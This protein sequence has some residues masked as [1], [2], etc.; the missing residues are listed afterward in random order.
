MS[1]FTIDWGLP[2]LFAVLSREFSTVLDIGSGAGEHKRFLEYHGK[3]VKSVDFDKEADYHGDFMD[4][5]IPEQFDMVWCSHVLEHQRNVG[6][7]LEKVYSLIAEDGYLAITVPCHPQERLIA[8][9]VTAWSPYLLCYNLVLAGFDCSLASVFYDHEVSV[10]V[11]KHKADI[12]EKY[13]NS[14][15]GDE[16]DVFGSVRGY[17][18]MEAGQGY[19]I[20]KPY[21]LRWEVGKLVTPIRVDCRFMAH[22]LIVN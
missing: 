22:P 20:E 21:A 3:S 8:G 1:E 5:D 14:V 15:I 9:H 16:G 18:P 19:E 6:A 10:I 13:R 4:I 7:F 2:A 11:Q 12:P 17:F